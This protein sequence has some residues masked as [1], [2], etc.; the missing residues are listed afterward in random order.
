MN[1]R[2]TCF[3][4]DK[5]GNLIDIH[6]FYADNEDILYAVGNA[7]SYAMNTYVKNYRITWTAIQINVWE[8][9]KE[10]E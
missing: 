5:D 6:T 7:F 2:Q 4:R 8:L 3:I 1:L 9:N 10:E